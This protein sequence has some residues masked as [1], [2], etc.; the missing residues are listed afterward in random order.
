M[1]RTNGAA[2]SAPYPPWSITASTTYCGLGLG[3]NATNQLLGSAA[4]GFV[5]VPVFPARSQF[6][7]NP[8]KS[9]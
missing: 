9:A 8:V 4:P 2:A 6:A 1:L 3:P 5:A 7:G